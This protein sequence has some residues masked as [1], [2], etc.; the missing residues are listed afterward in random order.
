MPHRFLVSTP[1]IFGGQQCIEQD[2]NTE[3]LPCNTEIVC[4]LVQPPSIV[5]V[6]HE[7]Y[8]SAGVRDLRAC[9]IGMQVCCA[10]SDCFGYTC[11]FWATHESDMLTC[12]LLESSYAGRYSQTIGV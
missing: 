5:T 6:S 10:S 12:D 11:D 9:V 8:I 2:G 7:T 3:T 1:A 4:Q